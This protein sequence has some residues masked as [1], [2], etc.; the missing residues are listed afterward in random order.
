MEQPEIIIQ[1]VN[2][3]ALE[4]STEPNCSFSVGGGSIGNSPS[5]H[6]SLYDK[7]SAVVA[8]HAFIDFIDNDFCVQQ[9]QGDVYVN[10]ASYPLGENNHALLQDNDCFEIGKFKL[11]VHFDQNNYFICDYKKR[12]MKVERFFLQYFFMPRVFCMNSGIKS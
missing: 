5:D 2:I 12:S 11:R 3:D 10:D 4:R 6:W 8:E 9:L 1:I 7:S